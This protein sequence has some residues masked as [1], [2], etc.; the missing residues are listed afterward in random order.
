MQTALLLTSEERL[1]KALKKVLALLNIR[2]EILICGRVVV[3][4]YGDFWFQRGQERTAAAIMVHTLS[5]KKTPQKLIL[6]PLISS[7]RRVCPRL[8]VIFLRC[9]F[10]SNI[11]IL[12]LEWKAAQNS[13]DLRKDTYTGLKDISIAR[14]REALGSLP[15]KASLEIDERGRRHSC[16]ELRLSLQHILGGMD[17]LAGE[18][19]GTPKSFTAEER[20]RSACKLLQK[21][22]DLT[23]TTSFLN[24]QQGHQTLLPKNYLRGLEQACLSVINDNG[25]LDGA[26]PK[27]IQEYSKLPQWGPAVELALTA[28]AG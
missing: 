6:G 10:G 19:S 1:A 26:W 21:I 20:R 17:K 12:G 7:S 2:L 28:T 24:L 23:L 14:F 22:D 18:A 13:F 8:F 15:E 25:L 5:T 3:H 9:Y 11:P 4:G 27:L 16:N